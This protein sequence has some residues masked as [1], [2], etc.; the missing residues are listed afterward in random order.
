M[1]VCVHCNTVCLQG[2]NVTSLW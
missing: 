1:T 2:P